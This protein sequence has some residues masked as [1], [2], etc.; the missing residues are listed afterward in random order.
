M[1]KAEKSGVKVLFGNPHIL[2]FR[3]ADSGNLE[4]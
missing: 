3:G 2:D 1:K 4:K